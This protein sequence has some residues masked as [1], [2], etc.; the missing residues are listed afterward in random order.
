[1]E[2]LK[3]APRAPAK[4]VTDQLRL[5][6]TA[7]RNREGRQHAERAVFR[8]KISMLLGSLKY[9]LTTSISS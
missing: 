3:Q 5:P 1:M 7:K 6:I 4:W 8:F 2:V 9:V